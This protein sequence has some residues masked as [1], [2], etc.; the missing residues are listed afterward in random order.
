MAD[1]RAVGPYAGP[2]AKGDGRAHLDRPRCTRCGGVLGPD[3]APHEDC[4]AKP[5]GRMPRVLVVLDEETLAT[6]DEL[7]PS[8][9]EAIRRLAADYRKRK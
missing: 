8:R 5:R 2:M 6:L 1:A 9:S 4:P 7:G 3:E